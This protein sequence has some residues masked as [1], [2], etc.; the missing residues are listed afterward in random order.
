VSGESYWNFLSRR[1]FAPLGMNTATNRDPRIIVPNRADGYVRVN[2]TLRN[3]DSDLTDVF[4]AGAIVATIDDL[5][6][7]NASLGTEAILTVQ[8][9]AQMWSASK[10]NDGSETPYGFGWRTGTHEGHK[11]IGHSGSTSGFSASLQRFPDD[12][13]AVIVLCNAEE[14]NIAT[15]MAKHVATLY[16][17][18]KVD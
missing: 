10:L 3:R 12:K 13:L 4:S 5:A 7:W 1:I 2:G 8:S 17:K 18:T 14:L 11:N 6:K 16:W 9:K 15:T